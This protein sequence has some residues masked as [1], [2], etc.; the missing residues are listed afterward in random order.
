MGLRDQDI[1]VVLVN[2]DDEVVG[3]GEKLDVHHKGLL[4]RAFSI[5]VFN[6]QGE[7]LIQQRA[8]SKYHEPGRWANTCCGHP[9]PGEA[10]DNAA[11]RRLFEE[12]GFECPL[13]PLTHIYYKADLANGMIE[14]EYV[15]A[16]K[17]QYN[18]A[19]I[20]RDPNEVDEIQW[21]KGEFLKQDLVAYPHKYAPWFA[22]YIKNYYEPIFC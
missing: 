16:F 12:L 20:R 9:F 5:F 18:G 13:V 22:H 1:S 17:G 19:P 14:H 8:A 6:D 2:Q 15:H 11:T 10:S 7:L 3:Y 21:V 4:H